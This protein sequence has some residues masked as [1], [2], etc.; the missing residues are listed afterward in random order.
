MATPVATA[1][2]TQGRSA[3]S[4]IAL[5]VLVAVGAALLA[6]CGSSATSTD[7]SGQWTS[8]QYTCPS[9]IPHHETVSI[10]E[11][12]SHIV[13][14]K[15][16]GDD[17]VHTGH[18]S[19]LGT[20]SGKTGVVGFWTASE[21]GTPGLGQPTQP[22][23]VE[24][25]NRFTVEFPGVGLMT[26]DRASGSSGSSTWWIWILVVLLLIVTGG[27]VVWYRQ[28]RSTTAP[29][30]YPPTPEDPTTPQF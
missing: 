8:N 30:Q 27:A 7:L 5:A 6:G 20:M 25:A 13:A 29:P 10:V 19:F 18:V 9:G 15:T 14:T 16:A 2:R 3:W 1:K 24:N 4:S 26:F 22:L 23:Q 21:G 12:G 28:R 17:C 11:T